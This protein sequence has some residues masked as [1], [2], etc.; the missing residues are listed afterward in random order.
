[1]A[2]HTMFECDDIAG[3]IPKLGGLN[4]QTYAILKATLYEPA[5]I[6]AD[7]IRKRAEAHE[8]PS[9]VTKYYDAGVYRQ[10]KVTYER[11][12]SLSD[13]ITIAE[14]TTAA[15]VVSTAVVF[16]GYDEKGRPNAVKAAALESGTST[17]PKTPFI[18]PAIKAARERMEAS[19]TKNFNEQVQKHWE[20]N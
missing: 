12:G 5:G 14:M 19:L 8:R 10:R 16:A 4:N 18:R 11:T 17:Q 9:N 6:L 2:R 20:D 13:S 15:G 7:E 3:I 1:M